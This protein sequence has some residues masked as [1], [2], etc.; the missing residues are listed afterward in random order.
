MYLVTPLTVQELHQNVSFTNPKQS[1]GNA[2]R[3]S[4]GFACV[5]RIPMPGSQMARQ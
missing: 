5:M 1:Q 2:P 4:H 3:S